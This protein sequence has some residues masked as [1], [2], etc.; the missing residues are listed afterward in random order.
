ML[1]EIKSRRIVIHGHCYGT[2]YYFSRISTDF[3]NTFSLPL[4]SDM[5][6]N[7]TVSDKVAAAVSY[8]KTK[9][10]HFKVK[11]FHQTAAT[12]SS[13]QPSRLYS[14]MCTQHNEAWN[15]E[16]WNGQIPA[17]QQKEKYHHQRICSDY[18]QPRNFSNAV[19]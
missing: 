5:L 11:S 15:N 18:C 7:L 17:T 10:T 2:L 6:D 16:K 9:H 14:F 8:S 1:Q 19:E 3:S 13:R 4:K 12:E